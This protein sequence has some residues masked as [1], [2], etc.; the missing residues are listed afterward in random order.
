V[1]YLAQSVKI[2]ADSL[3]VT[4]SYNGNPPNSNFLTVHISGHLVPIP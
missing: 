3:V 4:G 1:L 2:Y